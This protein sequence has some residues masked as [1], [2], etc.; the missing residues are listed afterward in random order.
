MVIVAAPVLA[1][2]KGLTKKGKQAIVAAASA[3]KGIPSGEPQNG[4]PYELPNGLSYRTCH[5]THQKVNSG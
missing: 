4:E 5:F 2:A 3:G 1:K